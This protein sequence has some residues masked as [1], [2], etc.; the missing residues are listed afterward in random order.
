MADTTGAEM[1]GRVALVTGAS[2]NPSI[3]LA[4]AMRLAR[5]GVSVV[6]NGRD[7]FAL[8]DAEALLRG[9]GAAVAS[10][11]GDAA[12]AS[13][14]RKMARRAQEEFGRIDYLVNTVG[15][16]RFVLCGIRD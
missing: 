6:I 8:A 10:V 7:A 11:E 4:T 1:K 5:D 9:A 13:V 14:C 2:Q 3:G 16:T 12:E 15:G